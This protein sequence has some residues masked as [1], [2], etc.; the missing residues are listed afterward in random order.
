MDPGM[1]GFPNATIARQQLCSNRA[2][3]QNAAPLRAH[4]G[5]TPLRV[6]GQAF[7]HGIV[8]SAK[9]D[10]PASEGLV[11]PAALRNCF[12][13]NGD[14]TFKALDLEH[15]GAAK[16]SDVETYAGQRPAL[17]PIML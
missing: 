9:L 6:G 16:S 2:Q 4:V 3:P 15:N 10:G 5:G 11:P 14:A 17:D 13:R 12:L 7:D 1:T 8:D